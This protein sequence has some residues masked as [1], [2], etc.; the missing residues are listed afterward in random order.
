M[1]P[2]FLHIDDIAFMVVSRTNA[3][4]FNEVEP[5]KQVANSCQAPDKFLK[6]SSYQI[7]ESLTRD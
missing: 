2:P 3:L 6:M 5:E 4:P 7:T 1:A